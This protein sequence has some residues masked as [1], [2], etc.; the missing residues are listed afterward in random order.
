MYKYNKYP[1]IILYFLYFMIL[2]QCWIIK[3]KTTTVV[4]EGTFL[5]RL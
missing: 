2:L 1:R 3:L 5:N 4:D